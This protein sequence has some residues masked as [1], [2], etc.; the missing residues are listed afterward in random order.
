MGEED[1]GS[2][3]L[4][5]LDSASWPSRWSRGGENYIVLVESHKKRRAGNGG[6]CLGRWQDT[7]AFFYIKDAEMKGVREE[8]IHL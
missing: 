4:S 5:P 3:A 1:S 2:N 6:G 8:G 7:V